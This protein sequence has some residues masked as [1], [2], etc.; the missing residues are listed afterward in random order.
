MCFEL[1]LG[2]PGNKLAHWE[3][4]KN[5]NKKNHVKDLLLFFFFEEREIFTE[6]FLVEA[7]R[8]FSVQSPL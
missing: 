7:G 3:K 2:S 8:G 1:L 5:K 4:N 6:V